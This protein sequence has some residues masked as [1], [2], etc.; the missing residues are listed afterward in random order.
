MLEICILYLLFSFI[1]T[2]AGENFVDNCRQV[3]PIVPLVRSCPFRC[4][5]WTDTFVLS[6]V[7][8]RL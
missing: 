7:L 5:L 3:V 1:P 6:F 8:L 4:C 2:K